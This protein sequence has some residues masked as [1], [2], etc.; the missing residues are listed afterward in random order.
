MA[1]VAGEFFP[2]SDAYILD[3]GIIDRQ[4]RNL[5][6]FVNELRQALAEEHGNAKV[7]PLFSLLVK[8][9]H[10][11]FETEE[12]LMQLHEYPDYPVHKA[13]HDR[14]TDTVAE[15]KYKFQR[16]EIELTVE[17]ME[18]LKDWAVKHILGFDKKYGPFLNS[19]GVF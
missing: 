15:F 19:K 7:K 3:I 4:H 17:M 18:F 11:H 16:N 13:E 10:V 8:Y 9:A 1:T 14:L 5:V 2:W 12:M 6:S